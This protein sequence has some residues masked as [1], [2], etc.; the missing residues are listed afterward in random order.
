LGIDKIILIL[1]GDN[2]SC[3]SIFVFTLG[4]LVIF[5][6]YNPYIATCG[7][8]YTNFLTYSYDGGISIVLFV[9]SLFVYHG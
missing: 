6:L 5:P 9:K 2:N 1:I 8:Y 7:S 4:I 3:I